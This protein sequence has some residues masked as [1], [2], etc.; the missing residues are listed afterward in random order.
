[1]GG[2]ELF[3]RA[4]GANANGDAGWGATGKFCNSGGA[5]WGGVGELDTTNAAL[6]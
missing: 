1:M 5:I 4:N 2:L 6:D 3:N